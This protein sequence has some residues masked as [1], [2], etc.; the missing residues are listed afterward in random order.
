MFMLSA[1][2][3]GF[4][5]LLAL[6]FL[7]WRFH[8]FLKWRRKTT[9]SLR[10]QLVILLPLLALTLAFTIPMLPAVFSTWP[11]KYAELKELTAPVES[12]QADSRTS[13]AGRGGRLETR[14]SYH[15]FFQGYEGFLCVPDGLR[16]RQEDFLRWAGSEEV[17]FLYANTGGKYTVYQIQKGSQDV[18]L[19][20]R[21][22]LDPLLSFCFFS[23]F[24]T[25]SI[26]FLALGCSVGLVVRIFPTEPKKRR[27]VK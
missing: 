12:V 16:F 25:L 27:H 19:H 3:W 9:L 8:R 15:V 18:F 20:Y 4:L 14:T 21:E 22:A 11:A 6:G 26:E 2:F 5:A 1:L 10:D 13:S 24:F 7:L 23:L 17:T